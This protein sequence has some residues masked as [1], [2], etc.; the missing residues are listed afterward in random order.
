MSFKDNRLEQ[1]DDAPEASKTAVA[2]FYN[3]TS[4]K[5]VVGGDSFHRSTTEVPSS[6]PLD[7]QKPSEV[8]WE[9]EV[10][11][12]SVA[13]LK[14]AFVGF[15]AEHKDPLALQQNFLLDG[16]Q[17]IK[18]SPLGHL[19]VLLTSAVAGEVKDLV[20]TVGWWCTWFDRFEEWSPELVSHHRSTWLRCFGVP[21]HAWGDALFRSIAFKHGVFIEVDSP[22]KNML[23]GDMA[24]IKIVTKKLT[25]IDSSMSV[26]VL[27][28]TF[29][30]R[31]ME[32]G[33]V[34][35]E[36]VD[37]RRCHCNMWREE[38]SSRGSVA[39]A[40]MVAVVE[41]SMEE[42]SE[43][44]WSENGQVLLGVGRQEGGKGQLES[45]RW[46]N[47]Q[48]R[49][50]A[51]SDTHFSG[52]S[53]GCQATKVNEG[54]GVVLEVCE[55]ILGD[56]EGSDCL[57]DKDCSLNLVRMLENEKATFTRPCEVEVGDVSLVGSVQDFSGYVEQVGSRSLVLRTRERDIS[58]VGPSTDVWAGSNR[59]GGVA[60]ICP[61]I[62]NSHSVGLI[63]P[64][65][66]VTNDVIAN[67]DF[68]HR[69][70]QVVSSA[71]PS[72]SE[73][74][75]KV[76]SKKIINAFRPCCHYLNFQKCTQRKKAAMKKKKVTRQGGRKRFSSSSAESDPIVNPDEARV[77]V[78]ANS[79]EVHNVTNPD[80]IALEVVLP[81]LG[82][83][84]VDS[85]QREGFI[86]ATGTTN[87]SGVAAL[88]G[89]GST[90][91]THSPISEG[92]L[93][94][95]DTSE[96]HHIIDIQEELG[97]TFK[98]VLKG[99]VKEWSRRTYGEAE[100]KKKRLIKDIL[101]LDLKS[102]TTG[103][104]QGEIDMEK[105][106]PFQGKRASLATVFGQ[107]SN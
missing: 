51:E 70:V 83:G 93:V 45:T 71:V 99:V 26:L 72:N 44:D 4:F 50:M 49:G 19:K 5:E 87:G 107:D 78:A 18:V 65:P 40:S 22:T 89:I 106:G 29:V 3:G 60:C 74:C 94:D 42:G 75:R 38:V 36:E 28:K 62:G 37:S 9:V 13:K 14:G 64:G 27:G 48:L 23:R 98:G 11:P 77:L 31:V 91:R 73:R 12:E 66:E 1:V 63:V 95:R 16:Y 47:V 46:K 15:L 53:L 35:T 76:K 82:G 21:L 32:E 101:A 80:G 100:A 24:R 25:L 39:G 104:L 2:R 57:G 41:G 8:V 58:L 59:K 34:G 7:G 33:G 97:I 67:S 17:N 52:N 6:V 69:E 30:I 20:G 54:V 56:R 102:E 92:R 79:V 88:V 43:G 85:P 86:A 81:G 105:C 90:S 84:D 10:E 55:E 96:A 61:V 68:A 103:L